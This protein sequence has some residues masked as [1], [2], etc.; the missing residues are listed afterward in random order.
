MKT[1]LLDDP[2]QSD[3]INYLIKSVQREQDEEY[4]NRKK[5]QTITSDMNLSDLLEDAPYV[6]KKNNLRDVEIE[7]KTTDLIPIVIGQSFEQ[8]FLKYFPRGKFER[9]VPTFFKVKGNYGDWTIS[10]R[11]DLVQYLGFD[12]DKFTNKDIIIRDWKSTSAFQMETVLREIRVF[13]SKGKLPK[14]KYFWQLQ[15][16]RYAFEQGGYNVHDLSLLIYCRHWTHRKSL[17][18][19]NYPK[20]EFFEEPLPLLPKDVIEKHLSEK[21]SEHQLMALGQSEPDATEPICSEE[22]RW[23]RNGTSM[24]CSLYCDVGKSGLC[25]QY[26]KEKNQNA[27]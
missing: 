5:T 23:Y 10:G 8:F 11:A 2:N 3:I 21:V 15:A 4:L 25:N 1:R 7:K 19:N 14:H 9:E 27:K 17:E 12:N 18:I 24:R 26:N 20:S 22:T 6:Y 16:Y 13:K